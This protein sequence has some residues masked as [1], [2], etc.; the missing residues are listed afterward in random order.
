MKVKHAH[1]QAM[2]CPDARPAKD[3]GGKPRKWTSHLRVVCIIR[4]V[5][6]LALSGAT[7]IGIV[8]EAQGAG[9]S[10]GTVGGS[11]RDP[12]N[13]Q[14]YMSQLA[15]RLNTSDSKGLL[16]KGMTAPAAKPV[17]PS[18]T[19]ALPA[20]PA[21]VA[22]PAPAAIPVPTPVSA[23]APHAQPIVG[24]AASAAIPAPTHLSTGV[25]YVKPMIGSAAPAATAPAAIPVPVVAPAP[26]PVHKPVPI[27]GGVPMLPPVREPAQ[28]VAKPVWNGLSVDN[29]A[30]AKAME[31]IEALRAK[32]AAAS[33]SA[34]AQTPQSP[35][36]S[37]SA[38]VAALANPA[39]P[40]TPATPTTPA[41]PAPQPVAPLNQTLMTTSPGLA[42]WTKP[43]ASNLAE[44]VVL[45]GTASSDPNAANVAVPA[46]PAVAATPEQK[47]AWSLGEDLDK[48]RGHAVKE[49]SRDSG[50]SLKKA[51]ER[52]GMTVGDGVNVFIL[53]YGSDKAK[54]FRANDGKGLLDNPGK[55]PQ[56]AGTAVASFADGVY[57]LADLITLDAL[58]DPIKD[59]YKDNNPLVRPLIF[60]GRTIGGVWKTT[61]EIG[62]SV[63]WGYFDNVT[64]CVGIVVEDILE[65]FK[66]VGQAA[67]NLARVPVQLI[68][69]GKKEN[70]ERVMDWVLLVPLEFLSNSAEMKGIANMDG[71]KTAFEDKG[72]IGSV[73]EFGG[74][75]FLAYRAVD[76]M[77]DKLKDKH[78]HKSV[79]SSETPVDN[80]TEPVVT[81][82]TP[83]GSDLLF[84]VDG[85]W[86]TVTSGSG[87]VVFEGQIPTI[88]VLI[89]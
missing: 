22:T 75:T 50:E 26:A 46:T 33:A 66:H 82:T 78:H 28:P 49:G 51:L 19:K 62:N 29:Q 53:G 56:Q 7:N 32:T 23:G 71:Y 68:A 4:L 48:Y 88:T 41:A 59:V 76:E 74:S 1:M 30:A 79:S 24:S 81:P 58:P 67:T 36:N 20:Q 60:T 40:A 70:A 43:A 8:A 86:P 11:I 18:Q 45:D 38:A 14:A 87:V 55:V 65:L 37:V 83:V 16:M 61:E 5:G 84:I 73:L 12:M 89:E 44:K 10:S 3:A 2:S 25:P 31:Q 57:S 52:A 6:L 39:A 72:V 15:S 77:V 64:G 42:L 85:E 34:P 9:A 54:A 47:K 13:P 17:Q 35:M 80:P 27:V 69:G 63:T 21:A